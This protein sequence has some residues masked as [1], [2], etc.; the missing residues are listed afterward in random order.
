M[1]DKNMSGKTRYD[2]TDEEATDLC[3]KVIKAG[4][5]MAEDGPPTKI[6]DKA[7]NELTLPGNMQPYIS[8]SGR[9]MWRDPAA[10]N[11]F[12]KSKAGQMELPTMK[13]QLADDLRNGRVDAGV[14]HY[15][16]FKNS[17][18]AAAGVRFGSVEHA[19]QRV[20]DDKEVDSFISGLTSCSTK[21][22]GNFWS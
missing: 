3:H 11:V 15:N 8:E 21:S 6:T 16:R 2:R 22:H 20:V 10:N 18:E 13:E 5:T 9:M 12:V 14:A 19:R 4:K 7:G 17:P 1:I